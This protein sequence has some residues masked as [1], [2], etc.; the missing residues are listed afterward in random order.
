MKIC[1][2]VLIRRTKEIFKELFCFLLKDPIIITPGPIRKGETIDL[3]AL[4]PYL[5]LGM[6]KFSVPIP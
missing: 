6:K 3:I 4:S 1:T 2:S 5:S